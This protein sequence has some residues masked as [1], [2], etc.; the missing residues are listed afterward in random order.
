MD[1]AQASMLE[2]YR[3][4]AAEVPDYRTRNPLELHIAFIADDVVAER[5]RLMDAGASPEGEVTTTPS[6]DRLAM[7]RDPWGVPIQLCQR[8]KPFA[9]GG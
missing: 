2:I 8:A 3:N 6:G 7:L 5:Q 4:P 1:G 9:F